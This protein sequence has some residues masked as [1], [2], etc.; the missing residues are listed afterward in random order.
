MTNSARHWITLDGTR[1]CRD[2][3]GITVDNGVTRYNSVYRSDALNLL[4]EA[5][6]TT[7]EKL[8]LTAIVDLRVDFEKHKAPNRLNPNLAALQRDRSFLPNRTHKLFEMVN[9]G[10][11]D[12]EAARQF[13]LGQYRVLTLE[14][15]ENYRAVFDDLLAAAGQGVLFHCTSGKDRTG[16]MSALLL[17]PLGASNDDIVD[18]YVLTNGRIE[19]ISYLKHDIDADVS[20]HIM[21]ADADYME[22]ALTTMKAEYGSIDAYLREAIGLSDNERENLAKY[23]VD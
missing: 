17:A 9:N 20:R 23:L 13:M 16:M 6:Q 10:E 14:H 2:L 15:T 5:D 8:S 7:L 18:D 19:P 12:G 4:S 11:L 21:A 1:N 3:G 22:T